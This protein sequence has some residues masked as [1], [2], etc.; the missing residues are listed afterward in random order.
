M[1]PNS[2]MDWSGE[3]PLQLLRDKSTS[4][5]SSSDSCFSVMTLSP[6]IEE[7]FLSF[8]VPRRLEFDGVF[9][10]TIFYSF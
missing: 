9:S 5:P 10:M 3:T 4:S 1:F 7:C 8:T 2:S 6:P